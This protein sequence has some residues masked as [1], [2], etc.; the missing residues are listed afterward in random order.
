M[1]EIKLEG[2]P[3]TYYISGRAREQW[4]LFLHAAFADHTMF[5]R[6]TEYFQSRYN[7]LTLDIVGHGNSTP[8]KPSDG[9]DRM[10]AWILEIFRRE[11]IE[12]AHLVGVSLGAVLAQDF[13]S[14]YPEKISSLACFGGYDITRFDPRLQRENGTAQLGMLLKGFISMKWFAQA[15]KKVSAHTPQAQEEFLQMNLRFSRRGFLCLASLNKMVNARDPIPRDYPLLIGCGQYDI[16][17]EHT[18][19]EQ[20]KKSE[21]D[22]NL[23]ILQGAG[24][25]VNMDVPELFNK[26]LEQ[27]WEGESSA[28]ARAVKN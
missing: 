17:S 3:L 20:W 24:H 27:F 15:N 26:T 9:V 19:I 4:V 2:A 18:A 21:P 7:V 23:A 22:C 5:R 25:C 14:R 8:A 28:E 1:E 13:A 12:K 6:Q 10:S 16:P 11:R